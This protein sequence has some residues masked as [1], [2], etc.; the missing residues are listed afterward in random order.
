MAWTGQVPCVPTASVTVSKTI[1]SYAPSAFLSLSPST[2]QTRNP[3][4][5]LSNLSTLQETELRLREK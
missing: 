4:C 1:H 3:R 5:Y 2:L